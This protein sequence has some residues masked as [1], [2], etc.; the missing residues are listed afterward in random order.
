MKRAHPFEIADDC[1][2]NGELAKAVRTLQRALRRGIEPAACY[3]RIAE[4]FRVQQRWRGAIAAARE[5]V[6]MAPEQILCRA[7]LIDIL[8]ESG[9]VEDAQNESL[10]WLESHPDNPFA[11]E[12]LARAYEEK[13]DPNSALSVMNRLVN[14]DPFNHEYRIQRA[15]ILQQKGDYAAA[16][17]DLMQSLKMNP[18]DEH[19]NAA[20]QALDT[21]DRW[22]LRIIVT[23]MLESAPFRTAFRRDRQL[24]VR[25]MGFHLSDQGRQLLEHVPVSLESP[26]PV[27][28]GYAPP[29]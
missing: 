24:A 15:E 19:R 25:S 1:I 5:A 23:L 18:T 4:L 27:Y 26:E 29:N 7:L 2:R 22:Q 8:L 6:R 9:L 16:A 3:Y 28:S 14:L 13:A 12:I 17:R 21:L 20:Q 10:A 11:L